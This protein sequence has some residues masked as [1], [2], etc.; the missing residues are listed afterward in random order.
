MLNQVEIRAIDVRVEVDDL[1][2]PLGY[3]SGADVS[4]V[5]M[6]QILAEKGRCEKMMQA[7]FIADLI[8]LDRWNDEAELNAKESLREDDF[9]AEHL[10]G[11]V[12]LAVGICTVGA[13]IDKHIDDCFAGGDYLGGMIAD[14]AASRAV[15][16]LG[17]AC[18]DFLCSRAAER[19]LFPS[20][21]ISPGYGRW[22]V[23]GQRVVFSLLN[24]AVIG[25]S[26]NEY[27]MMQPKK[28]VS[29]LI[30]FG[31][32]GRAQKLRHFCQ[33]CNFKNCSYRRRD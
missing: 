18:S 7:Q 32:E 24:P 22:D 33:E 19:K 31:K 20:C 11:A 16:E 2:G 12:I 13:E 29:F 10:D 21:R 30:P 9:L 26:L 23:A 6:E 14:V 4:S 28:S 15:E 17:E 3:K 25:V 27:C 1:L 8:S 5:I